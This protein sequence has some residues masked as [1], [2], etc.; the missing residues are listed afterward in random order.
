MIKNYL[1]VAYRN[2]FRD[3]LFTV[4][5]IFGLTVGI[6]AFL[7][8]SLFVRHELSFD[9]FH[10]K[11][12]RIYS[13]V[14]QYYTAE[15]PSGSESFAVLGGI[16]FEK[17][18]PE[19]EK[20]VQLSGVRGNLVN[21][22]DESFYEEGIYYSNNN[23]FDVFDFPIQ[24]GVPDLKTPNKAVITAS[25]AKKYFGDDDAIGRFITLNKTDTYEVS[26]VAE[27]LP[28]NS[29]MQ[30]NILVSDH[31]LVNIII[32]SR[33]TLRS[34]W[35]R[36]TYTYFLVKEGITKEVLLDQMLAVAEE[37]FQSEF[38]R[39]S[40]G[41][42]RYKPALMAYED[43]YLKSGFT[44]GLNAT[45]DIRYVYLFS[46]IALLILVIACVNYVNLSTAKSVRRA[47]ETG[48]RK[49]IGATRNQLIKLYITESFVLTTI[50]VIIAF[51]ITERI[52]P[53]YNQLVDRQLSLT[54]WGTEFV[55]TVV[56]INLVVSVI[57]GA[58]PA[59][60]LSSYKPIEAIR[61]SK[62]P[63]SKKALRRGLVLFQFLV[64]QLLIIA[65]I[66]IQ[67]QLTYLQN[68]D[69]G[70]NREQALYIRTYGEVD[71]KMDVFKQNLKSIPNVESI[72]LSDGIF[73]WAAITFFNLNSVDGNED[74]DP[75]ETV[76]ADLFSGDADFVNLME[77][78]IV[79]GRGFEAGNSSDSREGLLLNETAAKKFGWEN[80][81]G[82]K[83]KVW[84]AERHVV[85]VMKDFHNESLRAEIK[86]T[87][88]VVNDDATQFVNV[89]ISGNDISGTLDQIEAEWNSL[90]EGR[91]MDYTFYD[92]KFDQHYKNE[93]RLGN[94][95]YVF[96]AIAIGISLLGLV[97]L[98]AFTAEQRLREI[99]IRKVL[100]ASISQLMALMSREFMVISVLAFTIAIP[101]TY[102]AMDKWLEAFKYRIEIGALVYFIAIAASIGVA[103]LVVSIQSI[104]VAKSNPANVLRAE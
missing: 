69:L 92:D 83:L 45:S 59:F 3:K 25:I 22:L 17:S 31:K 88:V 19:I 100:G 33:K 42:L 97:G 95:F 23:I 51:A 37:K 55:F 54:Y 87:F 14:T 99:G 32:P 10:Q 70:Y 96:A 49:V 44:T 78:E 103:W 36:T 82:K 21:V 90:V 24:S 94:I 30:F 2:L 98:T 77:I 43:I 41:K 57:A 84:G 1:K 75:N 6:A 104:K 81:L 27:D 65:T 26:A 58:Y 28:S 52:L 47:K 46:S 12:D 50:S 80:P 86:P 13:H 15:G 7:L 72:A 60:K 48:L 16:E 66:I 5:N 4:L 38:H 11:G 62:N 53:F 74:A 67:S 39:D 35:A 71:D 61:G 8:I 102:Y 63:K 68:K 34:Q 40:E 56:I 29:Y 91:P 73:T 93:R 101:I 89:R 20:V 18:I 76:L 64:A 85:G 9:Q 79:E